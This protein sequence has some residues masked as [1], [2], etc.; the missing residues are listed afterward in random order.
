MQLAEIRREA[1]KA[2]IPPPQMNLADW[3][4]SA[5][6]LP[7]SVSSTPGNL[8]LWPYQRGIADAISD[9]TIEKVT[10]AKSVRIG[11]STL[12]TA[13]VA[14]YVA[15]DPSPL[16][17]L[18][19]TESDCRDYAVSDLEP[20][21]A[22]SPAL[23]GALAADDS[24]RSTIL[25][26][27]FPGGSLKIVASKSP[28]NLRR[29]NVRI[30]LIDEADAMEPGPEGDPISLAIKRTL[31]FANRKIILGSTPVREDGPVLSSYRESD[32]RVFECPC[33]SCGAFSEIRWQHIEWEP[34]RPDTAAWR[35]PECTDLIG[36]A[37]KPAMVEAGQWRITAPHV[38]GHAGFRINALSSCLPN[39]SWGR[40]AA[41][42]LVAKRSPDT[43]QTFINTILAEGWKE[44]G[45]ELDETELA[46]RVEDF[47]LDKL[48]PE[49]LLLTAGV[50]VQRDRLEIVTLGH[51]R[52][53]IQLLGNT[54]IWGDPLQP[55]V[56]QELADFLGRRFDHP[57]GGRL[58][59]DAA[60]IDAGDGNTMDAV[61]AFTGP[62]L[63]RRIVAIKGADGNRPAIVK[64][65][66]KKPL[67]IVGVDGL[68][69]NL[70]TR[71]AR[72]RSV[73]F[74]N[75]LEVRCFEELASERCVV[76]YRKGAPIRQWQRISGR[77]AECLDATV[78]ALAVRSLVSRDLS[79][80]EAE[81]R[82]DNRIESAPTVYRSKWING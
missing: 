41:E 45:E 3:A 80:R 71:L 4:E 34:D 5:L 37:C 35:C 20:T 76:I 79:Q 62:R 78:Y 58:G 66:G 82:L 65:T 53:E 32:Q 13:T 44:P 2:L 72:G 8:R 74:S 24:G 63:G 33:P 25:S 52:E 46:G 67:W 38:Q 28:R 14:N 56:W 23:A 16:L 18:L 50:D 9:P 6:V 48:P 27:R 31:S 7:G 43:L 29:H 75:T 10:L 57:H 19:P 15:N 39:A 17:L 51:G 61:L 47:G 12:L 30:L 81:L 55:T 70:H 54:V 26:R 64:S 42:F 73:R 11:L 40:L 36:E 49:T 77:R 69:T 60:A 22:A 59:F 68:K 21:F 1:L